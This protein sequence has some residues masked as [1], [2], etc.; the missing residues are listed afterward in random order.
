MNKYIYQ[1]YVE[2]TLDKTG[3]VLALQTTD[4]KLV[5]DKWKRLQK[6]GHKIK[7]VE[8]LKS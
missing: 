2:L 4:F 7:Y 3:D 6:Q 5:L 8:K 1:L